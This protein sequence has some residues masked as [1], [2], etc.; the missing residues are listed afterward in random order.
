ML[1]ECFTN[2]TLTRL[3]VSIHIDELHEP[4]EASHHALQAGEDGLQHHKQ[5]LACRAE[6][7]LL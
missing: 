1:Y 6:T 7:F 4:L 5:C 2:H 3:N